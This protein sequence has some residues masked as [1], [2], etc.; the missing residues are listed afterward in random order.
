MNIHIYTVNAHLYCIV[1]KSSGTNYQPNC[2]RTCVHQQQCEWVNEA[3]SLTIKVFPQ[4]VGTSF[5]QVGMVRCFQLGVCVMVCNPRN[6]TFWTFKNWWFG[7]D[8][9]PFPKRWFSGSSRSFLGM[10][11]VVRRNLQ[12]TA[13]QIVLSGGSTMFEKFGDRLLGSQN[14]D[15]DSWNRV[16]SG[17]LT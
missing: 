2:F 13:L 6:L 11:I 9:F 15:W 10:Y 7:S 3:G 12:L 16:P 17:K 5:S 1:Y 14:L 8:D 4:T